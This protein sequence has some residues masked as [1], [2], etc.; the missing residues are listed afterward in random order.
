MATKKSPPAPSQVK[1]APEAL[2]DALERA[3]RKELAAL[4]LD[5]SGQD[6]PSLTDKMKVFD[7]V[8]KLVAIKAKMEDD[9]AGAFFRDDER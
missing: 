8:L 3:L 5:T 9:E 7:R 1:E 2:V 6:A 4:S